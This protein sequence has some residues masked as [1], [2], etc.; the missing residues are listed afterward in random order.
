M[1]DYLRFIKYRRVLT[2]RKHIVCVERGPVLCRGDILSDELWAH[3]VSVSIRSQ[4]PVNIQEQKMQS[5]ASFCTRTHDLRGWMSCIMSLTHGHT[6]THLL[7]VAVCSVTTG[8][9]MTILQDNE[10]C[11]TA[12]GSL[13]G[14]IVPVCSGVCVSGL[15]RHVFTLRRSDEMLTLS[16][17]YVDPN[18][19]LKWM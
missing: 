12:A 6:N 1:N 9:G 5:G 17:V 11:V 3:W 15:W 10:P 7:R 2:M 16:H 19:E 13:T 8:G 4:Q 14:N 18:E